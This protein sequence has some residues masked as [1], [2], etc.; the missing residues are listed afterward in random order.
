MADV[1][2]NAWYAVAWAHEVGRELIE[3][4]VL[5]ESLVVYRQLDGTPAVMS[6]RC[7][8]RFAPLHLGKLVGDCVE[9]PYHG[10]QFDSAGSCAHNPHGKPIK[11]QLPI[12]PILEK[13]NMIWVWLGDAERADEMCLADFSCLSKQESGFHTVS[14]IIEME[15]NYELVSDNLLD[16]T[17]AT[18]L[19][20]GLIGSE[21]MLCAEREV[22]QEGT[23]VWSNLWCPNDIA[24]PAWDVLEGYQG[25]PVDHW[26]YMRW[27]APAHLLLDVGVTPPG[28]TREEGIWH[29]GVNI[30]T[31]I[32]DTKTRYFWAIS[33]NYDVDNTEFDTQIMEGI[34]LAFEQQDEPMIEAQQKMMGDKEFHELNPILL[35][36]DA[37]PIRVRRVLQNLIKGDDVP[38]PT[39]SNLVENM[40]TV[41]DTERVQ[42]IT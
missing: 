4:T 32:S 23:T 25:K 11:A 16:L 37:G 22:K 34:H 39:R 15:A 40:S 28:R 27:D 29:L 14:G 38:K 6:N 26:V 19:H 9:C 24:P 2:R 42:V 8:H 12:Y 30:L 41:A 18:Y 20:E 36:S 13:H 1:M 3:R 5:G 31:P 17:H 10:L 21:A 7:P 35:A 33:R